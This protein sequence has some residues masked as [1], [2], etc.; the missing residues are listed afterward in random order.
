MS[1]SQGWNEDEFFDEDEE[2]TLHLKRFEQMINNNENY[3]FD[4]EVFESIIDNYLYQNDIKK[5]LKA[6]TVAVSQHPDAVPI[7]LRKA[8]IHASS[9]KLNKALEILMRIEH[10]DPGNEDGYILKA[11][12]Y[13]QQR[14]YKEAIRALK[15]AIHIAGEEEADDLYVDLAFEYENLKEWNKAIECLHKALQINRENEAALYELA[16]C[17]EMSNSQESGIKFFSEFIDNN[18]YSFTAWYN[19]GNMFVRKSL[20]EKA[21]QAY[22]YCIAINEYFSSAYF[23]K[24][25]ALVHIEQYQQAIECYL[26]TFN[27]EEPQAITYCYMG[28]CYEKMNYPSEAYKHFLKATDM[29]PDMAEAWVGLAVAAGNLDKINMAIEYMH[30]ALQIEAS[31][32]DYYYIYAEIL[33]KAGLIEQANMAFKN[34]L[35]I[36]EHNTELFLDYTNFLFENYS[37]DTAIEELENNLE[38]YNFEADLLYRL[39]VYYYL[40]GKLKTALLYIENALQKDY[41]AHIK[42]IDYLPEIVY[43]NEIMQLIEIY[44][45]K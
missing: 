39:G 7:L 26:Q 32:A 41:K 3:F 33:E 5:A 45:K 8:E 28:E 25:N 37:A 35:S 24:A 17:Y 13:S 11:G 1:E 15:K 23:N 16:Y 22:D 44:K 14:N 43:N 42:M 19:L 31:N 30:K 20:Y 21:I 2:V 6:I 36:D 40:N 10:L 12:I 29:A 38:Y 18:P 27:Y 4:V 34:A 9:G